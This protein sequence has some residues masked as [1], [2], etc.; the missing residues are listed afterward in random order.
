MSNNA[1]KPAAAQ[2]KVIFNA[3]DV[4]KRLRS[5]R[6]AVAAT[7]KDPVEERWW[8]SALKFEWAAARS[9]ANNT[10]WMTASYTDEQN[11]TA[12]LIVR[13]KGEQ[14]IGQIK[15]NSDAGVQELI[16]KMKNPKAKEKIAPRTMK[17]S[18]QIN[19]WSVPVK[20][21]EDGITLL[22]ENGKPVLPEDDKLSP[23]FTIASL[24]NEAFSAEAGERVNR[25]IGLV[26]KATE[27]K[28]AD[29]ATT[30][31]TVYAAM[32]PRTPGDMFIDQNQ[33][34][35]L[36]K[37]FPAAKDLDAIVRGATIV[38]TTK[39]ASLVQETISHGASKN[40]GQP[41]PNPMTRITMNFDDKSKESKFA[42]FD[43]S[44]PYME[45]GKPKYE[46]AKVDGVPVNADNVHK[47]VLSRSLVDGIVDLSAVCISSMG[48]SM[49]TKVEVLVVDK[50]VGTKVGFEDLYDD[51]ELAGIVAGPAS[52]AASPASATSSTAQHQAPE[53]QQP[54]EDV[55][56]DDLI[57]QLTGDT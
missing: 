3:P 23:Y 39:V 4:A 32:G 40:A 46:P 21:A 19:K 5:L 51:D 28:K 14:H 12:P 29:K 53:P 37:L 52:T 49:P 35:N 20:T 24:V 56:H 38:N 27:M 11:L 57:N 8:R 30:G 42:I 36:R 2:K 50:P 55:N 41:L 45:A 47:F 16:L 17:P 54:E 10:S 34:T 48:I 31:E 1:R 15:P 26:A 43:K 18:I 13:V 44:L 7:G 22:E 25:G 6:D 33:M 9:G